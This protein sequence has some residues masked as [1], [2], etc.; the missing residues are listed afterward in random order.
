MDALE[1]A[2]AEARATTGDNNKIIRG[3]EIRRARNQNRRRTKS[4]KSA[5]NDQSREG[6]RAGH[7]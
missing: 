7:Q 6:H 2:V 5:E 3:R 4:N 1:L